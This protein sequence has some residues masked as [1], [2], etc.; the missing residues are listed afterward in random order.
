[1]TLLMLIS[2]G[3]I[4]RLQSPSAFSEMP[5]TFHSGETNADVLYAACM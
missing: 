3:V 5:I 4:R 2:A 1:M